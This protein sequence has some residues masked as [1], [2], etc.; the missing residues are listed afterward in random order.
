MVL[1]QNLHDV[2]ND[3]A[4]PGSNQVFEF[5]QIF[6]EFGKR[7]RFQADANDY[8]SLFFYPG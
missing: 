2:A 7:I 4:T 8:C 6:F 3:F 5:R 1:L